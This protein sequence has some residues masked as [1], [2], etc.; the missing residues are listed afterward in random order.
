[1]AGVSATNTILSGH[2][3]ENLFHT[4]PA[5]LLNEAGAMRERREININQASP[6]VTSDETS[7]WGQGRV[8]RTRRGDA[9]RQFA[10]SLAAGDQEAE[11]AR[12]RKREREELVSP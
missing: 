2:W 11:E 6:Q 1:M 4:L 12:R 3:L 9:R 5:G 7:R 10:G 8:A